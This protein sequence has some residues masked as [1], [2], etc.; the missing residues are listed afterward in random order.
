MKTVLLVDDDNDLVDVLKHALQR[1]GFRVVTALDGEAALQSWEA[2]QPDLVLLDGKLPH[3][4]GFEV[5]RHIRRREARTAIILL[6]ERSAETHVLEG[7]E[8]GADDYVPK[9]FSIK[10]L[11]ARIDA[12]LRR[13]EFYPNRVTP[14]ELTIADLTLDP[15]THQVTRAGRVVALTRV[16]FQLLYCLALNS[17]HIVRY[18]RLSA[19][20]WGH[21][22]G[23][24]SSAIKAH[25]TRVRQKLEL[26]RNSPGG[27]QAVSGI[28]YRLIDQ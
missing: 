21:R 11:L 7:F 5:C 23:V 12:V 28:G 6:T 20:A 2:E 3:M 19:A 17:G 1:R 4:D 9:P 22:G 15:D 8:A 24:S 25:I 27:I 14:C 13:Y 10:Q 18:S 16:E 26:S